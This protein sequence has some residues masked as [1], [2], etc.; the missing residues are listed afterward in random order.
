MTA[1]LALAVAFLGALLQS[2]LLGHYAL[3][4]VHVDLVLLAV[5]AWAALNSP[6]QAVL[7]SVLGGLCLDLL[8]AGPFGGSVLGLLL[9]AL[10]AHAIGA[11]AQRTQPLLAVAAL[12][13]GV[14]IYYL[15]T[16]ALFAV[17]GRPESL[18]E[19]ATAV[20]PPALTFSL[21]FGAPLMLVALW[22]TRV[23]RPARSL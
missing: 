20:L 16:A 11:R 6:R 5:L 17:A 8:S 21:L 7:W 12:P 4:G 1:Y 22:L 9:A 3:A 14:L 19:L 18:T 10:L 13:L 15:A 23:L 2:T